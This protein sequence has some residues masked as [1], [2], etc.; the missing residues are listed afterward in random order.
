MAV[1]NYNSAM[2]NAPTLNGAA[3]SMVTL[4]NAIL[5]NGFN[6]KASLTNLAVSS[7]VATATLTSHGFADNAVVTISGASPNDFNGTFQITRLSADAFTYPLTLADQSASGTIAAV[8]APLG[9]TKPYSYSTTKAAYRPASGSQ[10]YL[11]VDDSNTL[12]SLVKGYETMSDIDTGTN[13]FPT[14]AQLANGC[15]W[16]KGADTG[17][18]RTWYAFGDGT[19]LYLFVDWNSLGHC[20]GYQFGD[21][22]SFVAGDVYNCSIHGYDSSA[23]T[24]QGSNQGFSYIDASTSNGCYVVRPYS[25]VVGAVTLPRA[26]AWKGEMCRAGWSYPNLPDNGIHLDIVCCCDSSYRRGILKGLY[27][28]YHNTSGAFSSGD[29]SCSSP[30]NLTRKLMAIRLTCSG[31]NAGNCWIDITGPW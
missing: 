12:Y 26:S 31:P 21:F 6:S 8:V 9:W 22:N 15:G 17:T 1:M 27:T 3:G 11:R 24:N 20:V 23:P 14:A 29:L 19:C 5:V 25:G 7:N 13:V 16:K 2:T 4:L 10:F 18:A 28:G 30:T